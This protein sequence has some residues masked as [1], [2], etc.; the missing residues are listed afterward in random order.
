MAL[1]Y[2]AEH[3]QRRGWKSLNLIHLRCKFASQIKETFHALP[4][5]LSHLWA[6]LSD[7]K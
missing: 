1:P 7:T 4:L 5:P 2:G 6:L 3:L